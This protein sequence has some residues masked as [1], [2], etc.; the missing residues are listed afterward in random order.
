MRSAAILLLITPALLLLPSPSA[1][2]AGKRSLEREA[3]KAC[4]GGDPGKGV[5]L[6]AELYVDTDD[7]VFI[8][9]QGRCFEQNRRYEDAMA[10]FQEFLL[11]GHQKLGANEKSDA[12]QHIAHCRDMLAQERASV[13][14]SP[15]PQPLV[16]SPPVAP[17]APEPAPALE[18]PMVHQPAPQPIQSSGGAGLRTGG[19]VVAAFGVAALGA[20]VLLNVKANSTV[21]DMYSAYDGYSKESE[22]K[23][24]ETVA[25]VGYGLGTACVVTGA[26]LW[27]VGL[28]ARSGPASRVAFVP[29][30]G[31]SR[32]GAAL[33]GEF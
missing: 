12:D 1:L 18:P 22:R 23:T 31:T 17:P 25:W 11:A 10:R 20:G 8:F 2:A 7:I 27:A 26:V 33:T 15:A 5:Q 32:A 21:N 19:I 16:S 28:K 30:V 14:A 3:K 29:V 24:Y 4:L 9:N 6:L 13:P